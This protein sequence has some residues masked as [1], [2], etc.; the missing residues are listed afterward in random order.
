MAALEQTHL[1][2]EADM[3]EQERIALIDQ[4][5]ELQR[6]NNKTS[7]EYDKSL[8]QVK[9]RVVAVHDYFFGK[10]AKK[11]ACPSKQSKNPTDCERLADSI[12]A[13]L[14]SL[15]ENIDQSKEKLT[16]ATE[17]LLQEL[18]SRLNDSMKLLSS[19]LRLTEARLEKLSQLAVSTISSVAAKNARLKQSLEHLQEEKARRL[20]EEKRLRVESERLAK[21]Q[22]T[23]LSV[24]SVMRS[25]A[26][27]CEGVSAVYAKLLQQSCPA[28]SDADSRKIEE[29][30]SSLARY[31]HDS[32]MD[33]LA[34]VRSLASSLVRPPRGASASDEAA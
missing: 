33:R 5:N 19:K 11:E 23:L 30:R 24:D 20:E 34:E 32:A 16:E 28:S 8:R 3:F 26:S 14:D 31:M 29:G 1:A 6:A 17:D 7:R 12:H 18:D 10:T 13:H 27:T 9:E 15:V 2:E 25:V 21:T 22:A 4:L